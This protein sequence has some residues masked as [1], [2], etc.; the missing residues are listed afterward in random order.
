M[1]WLMFFGVPCFLAIAL[2][3]GTPRQTD[4]RPHP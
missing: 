3:Y 4:Y 2:V 1:W